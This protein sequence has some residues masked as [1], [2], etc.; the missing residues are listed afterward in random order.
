MEKQEGNPGFQAGIG[1]RSKTKRLAWALKGAPVRTKDLRLNA[2]SGVAEARKL[3]DRVTA[4]MLDAKAEPGDAMVYCVFARPDLSAVKSAEMSLTNG[5][6]D[7]AL[8]KKYLDALPIGFL[9]F[10]WDRQDTRKSIFGHA[11]PLIV[12]DPR[13]IQ[14]NAQ[15][16]RTE[17]ERIRNRLVKA[18]VIPDERN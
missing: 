9:V 4:L 17:T 16:L 2:I 11:R 7:L 3:R 5:P 18:G 8:A 13:A 12:E 6:S 1:Q 10:V 14:L 15:A